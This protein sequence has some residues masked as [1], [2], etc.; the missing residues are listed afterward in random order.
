MKECTLLTCNR[1]SDRWEKAKKRERGQKILLLS[2][3]L[4]SSPFVFFRSPFRVTVHYPLS[5]IHY[6]WN[7]LVDSGPDNFLLMPMQGIYRCP[8]RS[9]WHFKSSYSRCNYSC[10]STPK[11]PLFFIFPF[12]VKESF[13]RFVFDDGV[14]SSIETS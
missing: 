6:A 2:A 7:R 4:L 12:A 14:S 8:F 10:F 5:T 1:P 13:W 11:T 9:I 3:L